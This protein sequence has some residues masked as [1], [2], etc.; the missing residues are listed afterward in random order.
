MGIIDAAM[1]ASDIA[2]QAGQEAFDQYYKPKFAF[3]S[4]NPFA[5]MATLAAVQGVA[6]FFIARDNAKEQLKYQEQ[7]ARDTADA[8]QVDLT[9]AF[10]SIGRRSIQ[11]DRA[12]ARQT[13]QL[14]R[15]FRQRA[16]MVE[17]QAAG[18]GVEGGAVEEALMDLQAQQTLRLAVVREQRETQ[19]Y[20]T[21]MEKEAL[22]TRGYQQIRQAAGGP[23]AMPDPMNALF[24]IGGQLAQT[25]AMSTGVTPQ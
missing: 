3:P 10:N 11:Q 1:R 2:K 22:A 25:W 18:S 14:V 16:G 4:I 24:Q 13:A 5:L 8:V 23:V 15:E 17:A 20:A 9:N 7:L 21:Q 12:A 6:N 19:R